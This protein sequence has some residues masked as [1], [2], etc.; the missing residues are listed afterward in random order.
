MASN[1]ENVAYKIKY[2]TS[3]VVQWLRVYL[4][5]QRTWV[6]PLV[7]EDFHTPQSS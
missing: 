2:L 1:F 5:K 6:P 3:H 4:P 7:Q